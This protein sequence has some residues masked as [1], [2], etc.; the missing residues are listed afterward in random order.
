MRKTII[1]DNY[2]ITKTKNTEIQ[3]GN[4]QNKTYRWK[5]PQTQTNL[6]ELDETEENP[7]ICSPRF[8]QPK[9]NQA[10]LDFNSVPAYVR[11]H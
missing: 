8:D 10:R 2:Y 11:T 9:P 3:N 6:C 4:K 7:T 5:R 1:T